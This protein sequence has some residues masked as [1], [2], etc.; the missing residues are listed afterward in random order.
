MQY[1]TGSII[2]REV[3]VSRPS[4][5]YINVDGVAGDA[6]LVVDLLD[7]AGKSISRYR[8][9]ISESA[10]REVVSWQNGAALPK[11]QPFRI[12]VSWP[13]GPTEPRLYA[14]YVEHD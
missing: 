4:K 13:H 9:A 2:S 11:N 8:A 6:P 7:S 10:L 1:D 5:L 3:R 14:L 12:R